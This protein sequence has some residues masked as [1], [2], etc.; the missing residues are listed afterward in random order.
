MSTGLLWNVKVFFN[1]DSLGGVCLADNGFFEFKYLNWDEGVS[2]T[3]YYFRLVEVVFLTVISFF[4][5]V[6]IKFLENENWK[7]FFF[8]FCD[9]F[10][11][12]ERKK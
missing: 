11:W 4:F 9:F 6:I 12:K 3:R 1:F 5:F 7:T 8:N 2:D 10:F